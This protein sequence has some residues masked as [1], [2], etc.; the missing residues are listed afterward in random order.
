MLVDPS[1]LVQCKCVFH[2]ST[3]R[4]HCVSVR[5]DL[6]AEAEAHVQEMV[7]HV[8]HMSHKMMDAVEVR[9]EGMEDMVNELQST[10]SKL[11]K[12]V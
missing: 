6:D 4:M 8:S 3:S 12:K 7:D 5:R 11:N 2:I 1:I 9:L 10:V